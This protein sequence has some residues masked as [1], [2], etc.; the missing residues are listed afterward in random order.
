MRFL[1]FNSNNINALLHKQEIRE[2]DVIL[3][4]H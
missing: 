3:V 4:D 2:P 1:D